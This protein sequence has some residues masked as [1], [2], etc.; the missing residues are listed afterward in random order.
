MCLCASL[1]TRCSCAAWLSSG[2][3]LVGSERCGGKLSSVYLVTARLG[4]EWWG[5]DGDV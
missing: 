2:N 1:P 3:G 4:G 5:D